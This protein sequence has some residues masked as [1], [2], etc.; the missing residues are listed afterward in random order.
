MYK[1]IFLLL[2]LTAHAAL[3]SASNDKELEEG[4]KNAFR[5]KP[6]TTERAGDSGKAIQAYMH[7][8][9]VN[10]RPNERYDYTDYYHVK[11]QASFMG[12]D[13]VVI[14]E[15]YMSKYMGCCVDPGAG[16]TVKLNGSP[17]NLEKFAEANM[18]SFDDNVDIRS[19]LRGVGN[20][21]TLR[22]G[23]YATLSCRENDTRR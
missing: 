14:E 20:K 4:L 2:L 21:T 22:K 18:C 8:G 23:R 19:G 6:G 15:E 5:L 17:S 3:A 16:I 10:K 1:Q 9:I 7:E 11:K 13:L 12:H